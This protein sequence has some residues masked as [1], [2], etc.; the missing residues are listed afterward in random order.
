MEDRGSQT[1]QNLEDA[2]RKLALT[3]FD[4]FIIYIKLKKK[5]A[6]VR[7]ST[8]LPRDTLCPQLLLGGQAQ[9]NRS[10]CCHGAGQGTAS[11]LS[12]VAEQPQPGS[13]CGPPVNC[14]LQGLGV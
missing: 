13:P 9:A 4:Y 7:R 3:N 5:G 8:P 6:P 1:C 10:V 14:I 12:V 2:R 11:L